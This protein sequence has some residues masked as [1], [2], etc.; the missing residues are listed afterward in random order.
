V[1]LSYIDRGIPTK[2]NIFIATCFIFFGLLNELWFKRSTYLE[3]KKP[4]ELTNAGYHS[5]RTDTLDITQI[6]Y[7]TPI[8]QTALPFIGPSLMLI[9][10]RRDDGI[11][12]HS[13]VREYSY[14]ESTLKQFLARLKE[15]N[16]S[17]EL[18]IEYEEFLRG[19]RILRTKTNNT[20]RSVEQM[21][22]DKGERW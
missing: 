20:A 19:E 3:I 5:F 16:P 15:I 11:I 1:V 2:E 9:Y 13:T 10:V 12:A 21:L 8:P 22:R 14:D 4:N 18:D 17:I 7:I 6:R